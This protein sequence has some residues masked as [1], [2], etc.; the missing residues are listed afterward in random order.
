MPGVSD[1]AQTTIPVEDVL[2]DAGYPSLLT[3]S[4]N[5]SI[6]DRLGMFIRPR[7]V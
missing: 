6:G 3:H 5:C 7:S 4:R 2:R 1:L